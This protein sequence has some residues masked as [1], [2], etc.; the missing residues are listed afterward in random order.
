MKTSLS[1]SCYTQGRNRT[2]H[3]TTY[4][5]V[6]TQANEVLVLVK[7]LPGQLVAIKLLVP[8]KT[9]MSCFSLGEILHCLSL[10]HLHEGDGPH[11]PG[12]LNEVDMVEED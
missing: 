1:I 10:P 5:T 11:P 4:V 9:A 6:A 12:N 2:S 7:T 8:S 3:P